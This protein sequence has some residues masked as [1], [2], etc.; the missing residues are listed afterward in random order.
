MV[1]ITLE[2]IYA[3][4]VITSPGCHIT[5]VSTG[6]L[7]SESLC[8]VETETVHVVLCK[9]ILEASLHMSL[10]HL[11]FVVHIVVDIVRV[12][13]SHIEER[14]VLCCGTAVP[15]HLRPRMRACS[16]IVNDIHDHG[17]SS[18]VTLINESLVFLACSIIF[19]QSEPVVRVVSPA[20]VGVKLLDRHKLYGCH[21]EVLDVVEL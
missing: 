2:D 9:E 6:I 17:H 1:C 10:H 12:G 7:L 20:E 16:M 13:R 3:A 19:V 5:V 8:K 21:S 18:C 15:P 11:V 14:I 4:L